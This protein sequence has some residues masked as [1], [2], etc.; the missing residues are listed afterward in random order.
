MLQRVYFMKVCTRKNGF[1]TIN[2]FFTSQLTHEVNEGGKFPKKTVV[3][4]RL[5][6]IAS[7]SVLT[8]KLKT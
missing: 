2:S 5:E 4:R 6:S 3:L 1:A 8:T 7:N